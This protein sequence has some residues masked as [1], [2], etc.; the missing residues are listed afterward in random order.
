MKAPPV[1]ELPRR[2]FR[3]RLPKAGLSRAA[4][5]T[6]SDLLPVWDFVCVILA[7]QFATMLYAALMAATHGVD[8][9]LWN[10]RGEKILFA[11]VLAAFFLHRR[12]VGLGI[13][14]ARALSFRT[15][16]IRFTMF[17]GLLLVLGFATRSLDAMPRGWAALWLSTS[18]VLSWAARQLL[19][20]RR[21]NEVIAVVGAGPVANRLISHLRRQYSGR[22]EFVGVFD[23]RQERTVEDGFRSTGTVTD[24]IEL[25][26]ARPIDWILLTLPCTAE[27]PLLS[28][29]QRLK[30]LSVPIGLCPQN[31]GLKVPCED[32]RYIDSDLPV[33]VLVD[34]AK[35]RFNVDDYQLQEFLDVAAKFGQSRFDYVV[36]PNVD[37]LIRLHEDAAFRKLYD[38]AGYVLL[39][40]RF[41][42]KILKATQGIELPVCA[43][44]DLTQA[45]FSH[46]IV[47]DDVVVLIGGSDVQATE[48]AKR[49]SLRQLQHYNPSMG[50]IRNPTLVEECLDFI[51]SHS[52]FRFCLLAVG[53][54]QQEILAQR[55]RARGTARGLALCIGASIDFM[56]GVE[57]RA[58]V[59]MQ[60]RGLEW[61]YRLCQSPARLAKRYLLRGPRVFRL[62]GKTKVVLRPRVHRIVTM[63]R[64]GADY[65]R[66][67]THS[68]VL[69]TPG[70]TRSTLGRSN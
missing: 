47:P 7:G 18:F 59:W 51:E 13:A 1:H 35:I 16:S 40:S 44:S 45:L 54:P 65:P 63:P 53:S 52:P 70:R 26:K 17:L 8:I 56:T 61:F 3:T 50:F 68:D 22:V 5:S 12:Q 30:S 10:A 38:D 33:T 28:L 58:P 32:V 24:L 2:I 11:A 34:S 60:N 48:L 64:L 23:D 57:R 43:G 21:R 69:A 62:L 4:S 19:I 66:H 49:Y 29:V 9:N 27:R 14:H 36:T 37:H 42:S 39:D 6:A 15:F 31:V 67:R 46:V 55:L 25:G 41:L 20:Q